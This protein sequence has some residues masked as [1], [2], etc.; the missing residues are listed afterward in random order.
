MWILADG[1]GGVADGGERL[2]PVELAT[3]LESPT[4]QSKLA[5]LAKL[6]KDG[7]D[8]R[9]LFLWVRMSA[10]SFAVTD[11]L[12]FGGRLPIEPPDLPGGLSQLWLAGG[13]SAGGVVRAIHG[14]RW[15]REHPYANSPSSAEADN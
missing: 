2:L 15:V 3:H 12:Y 9:H 7:H 6:G 8:E 13:Y 10:F 14:D 11:N 4:M 1:V 5:K